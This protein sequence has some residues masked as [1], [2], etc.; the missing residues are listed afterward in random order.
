MRNGFAATESEH[1]V[2]CI[3]PGWRGD[4][5]FRGRCPSALGRSRTVCCWMGGKRHGSRDV[6]PWVW[7][8]RLNPKEGRCT[9]LT[10][11]VGP[12]EIRAS[13]LRVNTGP[14]G[15]RPSSHGQGRGRHK[16]THGPRRYRCV[17]VTQQQMGESTEEGPAP[18]FTAQGAGGNAGGARGGRVRAEA[19]GDGSAPATYMAGACVCLF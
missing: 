6:T 7:E 16:R 3:L 5:D 18:R 17:R 15:R 19:Q 8:S 1:R 9:S 10:P 11:L 13:V 4:L 2:L 14:R 12:G